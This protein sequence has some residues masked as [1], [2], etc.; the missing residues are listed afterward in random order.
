MNK[1]AV[2]SICKVSVK[3]FICQVFFIVVVEFLSH[4]SSF[5]LGNLFF[6]QLTANPLEARVGTMYQFGD[7]KLRLDIGNSIDLQTIQLSD[8]LPFSL[9]TDFFT[10]T[11]L[12]SEGRLKFP[13][14]TA[15]FYFGIN[16][17]T[18]WNTSEPTSWSARL[19]LAHISSHLVDGYATDSV[20]VRQK[21]FVY[22]REFIEGIIAAEFSP[23]IRIYGGLTCVW[24]SQPRSA[25]RFIPE[26]GFDGTYKLSKTFSFNYGYDFKIIGVNDVYKAVHAVQAGIF[27]ETS[28]NKGY[29]LTLYGYRGSSVHGMFFN[30]DDA[31]LG[32]GFQVIF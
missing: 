31:Y 29:L 1:S 4:S 15:D 2:S 3:Y 21:P 6:K 7:N 28:D 9:G 22:S 14:E 23:S 30:Q 24:S 10:L 26:L 18:K 11:R 13:V 16:A 5:A 12:R 27:L 8:S 20:F 17:A 19:R 32:I 25:N